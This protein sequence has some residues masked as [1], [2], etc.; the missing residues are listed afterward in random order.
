MSWVD[1][2]I[3]SALVGAIV[4]VVWVGFQ[5]DMKK[6]KDKQRKAVDDFE[7]YA[8]DIERRRAELARARA[9]DKVTIPL[10]IKDKP[11]LGLINDLGPNQRT[12]FSSSV[13]RKYLDVRVYADGTATVSV[14]RDRLDGLL[15]NRALAEYLQSLGK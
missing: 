3:V 11:L 15:H 14:E 13:V 8:R 6:R 1:W 4:V 2:L 7:L 9:E 5:S 12:S 10:S